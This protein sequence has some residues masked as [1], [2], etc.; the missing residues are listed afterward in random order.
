MTLLRSSHTGSRHPDGPPDHNTGWQIPG[1]SPLLPCSHSVVVSF[2]RV[3]FSGER[4]DREDVSL[5]ISL[6]WAVIKAPASE[7]H[8]SCHVGGEAADSPEA[9]YATAEAELQED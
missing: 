7:G 6:V 3:R 1:P 5:F 8:S 9:C 4:A 2:L